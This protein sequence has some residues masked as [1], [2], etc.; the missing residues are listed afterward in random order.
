MPRRDPAEI[1]LCDEKKEEI[2]LFFSQIRDEI[3]LCTVGTPS[4][5]KGFMELLFSKVRALDFFK[6]KVFEKAPKNGSGTKTC[7]MESF[8]S[9]NGLGCQFFKNGDT[10][11]VYVGTFKESVP[12]GE[13][14]LVFNKD[15]KITVVDGYWEEGKIK[16]KY[17]TKTP[18]I[19]GVDLSYLSRQ[20]VLSKT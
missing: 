18:T 13:G 5:F 19:G 2:N 9:K 20:K 3:L 6:G 7:V 1:T 16:K 11:Q 12:H 8:D 10:L 15:G 4:R 14:M 17:P